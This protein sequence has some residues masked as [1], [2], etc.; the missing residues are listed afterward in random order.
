MNARMPAV[1]AKLG[2]A[3]LLPFIAL[4]IASWFPETASLAKR[5]IVAYGACILSFLGAVHWGLALGRSEQSS[6]EELR[7][8]WAV[9]PALLAWPALLIAPHWGSLVV[10]LGL[11]ICWLADQRGLRHL[12]FAREYLGLRTRLTFVSWL[13]IVSARLAPV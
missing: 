11:I 6:K 12:P 3:A 8:V 7:Y 4:A 1:I 9:L 13:C 2:Y 5:A 10:S